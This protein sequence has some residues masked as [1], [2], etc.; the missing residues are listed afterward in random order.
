M[1]VLN[2]SEN[3][4]NGIIKNKVVLLL[5]AIMKGKSMKV[6]EEIQVELN[7]F[8]AVVN[9]ENDCFK[10]KLLILFQGVTNKIAQQVIIKYSGVLVSNNYT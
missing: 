2:I 4:F 8:L 9:R 7:K 10:E 3:K 1:Q 5:E 6:N